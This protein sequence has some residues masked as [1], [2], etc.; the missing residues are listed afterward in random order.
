MSR[1]TEELEQIRLALAEV[2]TSAQRMEEA[3][4]SLHEVSDL[5]ELLLKIG[6]VDDNGL[7]T[8]SN[9]NRY[10]YEQGSLLGTQDYTPEDNTP[11]YPSFP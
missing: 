4:R 8:Y 5:L 6:P 2:R 1:D 10:V 3:S 9:T 7:N 11:Q